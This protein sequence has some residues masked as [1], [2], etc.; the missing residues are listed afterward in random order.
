MTVLYI[1]GGCLGFLPSTVLVSETWKLTNEKFLRNRP[2]CTS[3]FLIFQAWL[4]WLPRGRI[5]QSPRDQPLEGPYTT[6]EHPNLLYQDRQKIPT[7][8]VWL[9]HWKIP[10]IFRDEWIEETG[11]MVGAAKSLMFQVIQ[12]TWNLKMRWSCSQSSYNS[13]ASVSWSSW[14]W[15]VLKFYVAT[16][17][18]QERA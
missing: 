12:W 14:K 17:L 16:N 1:P 3:A 18:K 2:W 8:L 7:W 9:V 11:W 10:I 13:E 6:K 5:L 15:C 4:F